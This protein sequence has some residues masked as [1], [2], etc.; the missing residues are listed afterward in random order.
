[1]RGAATND[2]LVVLDQIIE[3][4]E[5]TS[6]HAY[7]QRVIT[8]SP[9]G[10]HVRHVLDF[11][12]RFLEG[13]AHGRID[14]DHRERDPLV[15]QDRHYAVEQF[16]RVAERLSALRA[17]D[18]TPLFVRLDSSL[19]PEETEAWA[20]SSVRRELQFLI[21]HSVHHYALIAVLLRIQ[22]IEP[23][24]EFGVAPST[25]AYWKRAA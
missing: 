15:E 1:M 22:N 17:D 6:D 25:L 9:I 21:S 7:T 8:L 4:L 18:E 3:L 10:G 20:T 23:P 19:P 13:V 14:Y 24:A 11:Y 16:V 12:L 2:N 5:Q